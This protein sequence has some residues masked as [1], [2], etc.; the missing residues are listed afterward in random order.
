MESWKWLF[1]LD[2][3]GLLTVLGLEVIEQIVFSIW[4]YYILITLQ[5]MSEE[6][7]M[8]N[9][10]SSY[11]IMKS[12]CTELWKGPHSHWFAVLINYSSALTGWSWC[13]RSFRH[14]EPEGYFSASLCLDLAMLFLVLWGDLILEASEWNT[15]PHGSGLL[16]HQA[17]MA[18]QYCLWAEL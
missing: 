13:V 4:S 1:F 2:G 14:A 5:E 18:E 16:T 8:R 9:F 7:K 11:F 12:V 15:P 3:I 10:T 17:I 6:Y